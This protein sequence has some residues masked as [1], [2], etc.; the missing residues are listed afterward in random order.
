[1]DEVWKDIP[2]MRKKYQASTLGRFRSKDRVA[3][4]KGHLVKGR[5]LRQSKRK[6]GYLLI[7][8]LGK[9]RNSHR[10]IA[11]TFIPNPENKKYINHKNGV[12]DDNRINNLEW[13]T[14][15]ENVRH[16]IKMGLWKT[17]LTDEDVVFI[18][19]N[20][21]II[22][23]HALAKR[24]NICAAYVYSIATHRDKGHI[25]G[26]VFQTN[27]PMSCKP[28]NQFTKQGVFV[29]GHKSIQ[30]AANELDVNMGRIQE[31]LKGQ[32]AAVHGFI[33]KYA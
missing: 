15:S 16:A 11:Q 7:S 24:F 3:K 28:V 33:F 19:K 20:F 23:K 27:S 2:G 25:D 21:K 18:R 29:K 14:N 6:S 10:L 9:T 13:C 30:S 4:I 26:R 5:L 32:R 31:I 17:K 1:M 12:K 22:G 8:I